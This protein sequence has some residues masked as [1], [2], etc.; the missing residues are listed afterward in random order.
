MKILHTSDW[1]IGRNLYGRRRYEEFESFL[2]WLSG[3]IHTEQINVLVV[4]GDIFD[5]TT[6]SN[7]AQELYYQFLKRAAASQCRHIVI[8]GGNH[9]SPSFLN[10]PKQ[11]L[12]FL[13][14]HIIGAALPEIEKQI[15][16]LKDDTGKA[17]LIVV[18]VPYLRDRDIRSVETGESV[19]D[20]DD[21]IIKGI[22]AHYTKVCKIAEQINNNL[23]KKVPV[24]ATG[25]L[26]AAGG[27]VAK[28]DGVRELYIG[29]LAG[30]GADIFPEFIDYVA[31]GHLHSAQ[32]VA[33]IDHI[34]YSGS[35]VPMGFGEALQKKKVLVVD[36]F[37]SDASIKEV[38][39]P[40][41]QRLSQ[42]K[43]SL[44]QINEKIKEL[45]QDNLPVWVEIIYNGEEIPADLRNFVDEMIA[46]S[47]IE[48]LRIKNER[49]IDGILKAQD[50]KN[51]DNLKSLDE[52]DET[53]VFKQCM[54]INNI[55]ETQQKELSDAFSMIIKDM[56]EEI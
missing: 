43:G 2:N 3:L 17:E 4:A 47:K 50:D 8:I 19:Q 48:V 54:D 33:G 23:D 1:H 32:K 12:K 37:N 22:S 13:N 20:K 27:K 30:I 49:K 45:K 39:V 9:D 46:E 28:G 7:R 5:N 25:H 41:F 55:P 38:I 18:A 15:L 31:L 51:S 6:P 56:V 21:K 24:I 40:V 14:I 11:I 34:R 29:S 35:P 10:A 36:F 53:E 44:D 16:V 42:V 52:M 26:F